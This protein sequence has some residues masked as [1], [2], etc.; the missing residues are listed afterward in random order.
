MTFMPDGDRFER[1]LCGRGWRKAYRLAR[2]N[3]KF[4]LIGDALITAVA[5]A[6]RGPLVCHSL[7]KIRGAVYQALR[8]KARAG[9]L[10]FGDQSLA[11]PFRMLTDL[12]ADIANEDS[13]SVSTQ[14]AARAA[15]TVYL[16]LQRDCEDVTSSQIQDRLNKEL[17]ERILR[18]QF[19][20]RVREGVV[21]ANNRTAEEQMA[22]EDD[23]FAHLDDRLKK[24][25]DQMFRADGKIAIRAPRRT[26]PQR[27][28]TI[29]ELHEGIEVL[30]V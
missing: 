16:D 15:Q 19:L 18:H 17:G 2:A 7:A 26:T 6:L 14:L 27:K 22:W 10:H 5:A 23:L 12:L 13:N 4:D 3:E 9:Q 11:D 28:M 8:E 29:E 24:T 20:A 1:T 30:E 21:L 25:V